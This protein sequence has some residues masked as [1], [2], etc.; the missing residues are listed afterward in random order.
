MRIHVQRQ[1]CACVATF[2]LK[3]SNNNDRLL[4]VRIHVTS[5]RVNETLAAE[6]LQFETTVGNRGFSVRLLRSKHRHAVRKKFDKGSNL[7]G[8]LSI[9]CKNRVDRCVRW[10]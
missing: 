3:S 7:R 8:K 4:S 10:N 9:V 2:F 1:E 5:S 6:L